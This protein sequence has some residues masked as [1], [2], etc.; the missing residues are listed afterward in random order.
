MD[1]EDRD[2]AQAI[3]HR[4]VDMAQEARKFFP[5]VNIILVCP[6][7]LSLTD[8]M[9]RVGYDER[10]VGVSKHIPHEFRRVAIPLGFHVVVPPGA[11]QDGG[12]R[13]L[14]K[15][16]KGRSPKRGRRDRKRDEEPFMGRRG[17]VRAIGLTAEERVA[18]SRE[19]WSIVAGKHKYH[20]LRRKP[21]VRYGGK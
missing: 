1:A 17:V 20:S 2:I 18:I 14:K 6:P 4:C 8:A 15:P 12:E 5:D 9:R 16:K 10:S 19:V 7:R 21:R 3:A 13:E 11:D